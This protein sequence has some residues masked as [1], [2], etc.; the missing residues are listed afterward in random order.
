MKK[1]LAQ[2]LTDI[3]A[4]HP[5]EIELGLD[6]IRAVYQ[7]LP[8]LPQ[9][10]RVFTVAGTNGKGSV[11][12]T[13]EALGIAC[14]K[15][16]GV[17][18][19][20][21]LLCYNERVQLQQQPVS[22][23]E[24]VDAF[25]QIDAARGDIPLTYFEFG[26][27]AALVIF[28]AADLDWVVLE[29]GLGGRLDAVNIVDPGVAVITSIDLDHE[30]WL[31]DTREKIGFEKAGVLRAAAAFVCGDPNPPAT[32][33]DQALTAR[34]TFW[35]GG[36]FD[37]NVTDEGSMLR[38]SAPE[39]SVAGDS[40]CTHTV[41][42]PGG[43]PVL[44]DNFASAVQAVVASGQ[45]L[46]PTQIVEAAGQICLPGRQQLVNKQPYVMLDVGHNP[47][48]ARAL[49]ARIEKL[50]HEHGISRVICLVG[51]L[52]D[53]NH[54]ASLAGLLSQVD[55]WWPVSLDVESRASAANTLAE[56]L[57]QAGAVVAG[58]S[59]SPCRAYRVLYPELRPD[60]LLVV[61]G[62]FHTVADVIHNT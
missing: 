22:D 27:L 18:M 35:R 45:N 52:A 58:M 51:M 5:A 41:V 50:R 33:K 39:S 31:G 28:A 62:S 6:R 29:V 25:E 38:F 37:I 16:V 19:S 30:A 20:P 8:Q 59:D 1:S 23:H 61:F 42:L 2:W 53:K 54:A 47:Q 55:Q 57:W 4:L 13:I 46:T 26:T 10:C 24:L 36:E 15:R 40:D 7:R 12:K 11:V 60:D 14:D 49:A 32:V 44:P 17:Y 21:H 9:E 34:R 48:A 43:L 56:C 3:E